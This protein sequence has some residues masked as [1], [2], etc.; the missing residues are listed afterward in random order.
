MPLEQLTWVPLPSPYLDTFLSF[1]GSDLE[2]ISR[3]W[4]S[5]FQKI[6]RCLILKNQSSLRSIA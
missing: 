3:S 1:S 6:T 2:Q 5:E 4:P